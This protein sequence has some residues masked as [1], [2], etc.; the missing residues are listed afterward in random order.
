MTSYRRVAW[1]VFFSMLLLDQITKWLTYKYLPAMI[2]SSNTYPYGGIAVFRNLFGVDFS[3]THL[4]NRGAAWG[5]FAAFQ[6]HLLIARI[7]FITL[8]GYYALFINKNYKRNLAF[9]LILA[10]AI[11][12]V[13]DFFHYGS[14]I[15]MLHFTFWGYD[16]PVFNIAD[17]AI[18]LGV[19]WISFH[20]TQTKTT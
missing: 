19:I 13:I 10:G 11:G 12:N 2:Y 4:T 7:V 1:I 6:S 18:F 3:I 17:T 8:L 20:T 9:A 16:Y 5:F 15:D 14:V